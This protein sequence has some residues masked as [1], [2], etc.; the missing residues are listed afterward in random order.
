MSIKLKAYSDSSYE[1]KLKAPV[2]AILESVVAILLLPL[3]IVQFA[4]RQPVQGAAI[5][6]LAGIFLFSLVLLFKGR[7]DFSVRLLLLA[8]SIVMFL[9]QVFLQ[10]YNNALVFP[11]YALL[12]LTVLVLVAFLIRQTRVFITYLIASAITFWGYIFF[13]V[14][15]GQAATVDF[16]LLSQIDIAGFTYIIC[17]LVLFQ[18]KRIFNSVS[19]DAQRQFALSEEN[20]QQLSRIMKEA[21]DQLNNT[22]GLKA[23]VE[24]TQSATSRIGGLV[25]GIQGLTSEQRDIFESMVSSLSQ[26]EES[27]SLLSQRAEEQ[28]ANV[29]QSAAA[30]EEMV[31][32]IGNV[33][34]V[35]ESRNSSVE[36]LMSSSVNGAQ[37]IKQT[38]TSFRDVVERIG[39]IREITGLISSIAAQTNLLAMNAAIEAAHAGD[40][41]RGFAVV[42]D[43]IRKLAENSS[44]N[45]KDIADNLKEL[46]GSIEATGTQVSQTEVSFSEIQNEVTQVSNAMKEIASS[47][48]ELDNGSDEILRA[49]TSL[50]EL[51]T[52]VM[53]SVRV[54]DRDILT[55][56]GKISEGRETSRKLNSE[57]DDIVKESS[58][59]VQASSQILEM[60]KS[61]TEQS[62]SLNSQIGKEP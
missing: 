43:E 53:E 18:I 2:A 34:K 19:D 51:T 29:T 56:S 22:R 17:V 35:I 23:E 20:R 55:I 31:A 25:E 38:E 4:S 60:A 13:V 14:F 16:P 59:I 37:M 21:A 48:R 36:S 33:S 7:Y 44:A 1:I 40:T 58:S 26:L 3:S 52:N 42:A 62:E 41:G 11:Q 5:L 61:L 47:T 15:S 9:N 30:I 24:S 57:A 10:G 6:F 8:A 32:S 39:G 50:S 27:M 49:T 12:H 45:A 46:I 54:A 28:S